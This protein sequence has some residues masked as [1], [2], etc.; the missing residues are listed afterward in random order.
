[1]TRSS[2]ASAPERWRPPSDARHSEL[3]RRHPV[4]YGLGGGSEQKAQGARRDDRDGDDRRKPRCLFVSFSFDLFLF[5]CN[6]FFFL[7]FFFDL[8]VVVSPP[9]LAGRGLRRLR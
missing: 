4:L 7:F 6:L 8:V 9:R 5:F 3:R 2:F 1:L